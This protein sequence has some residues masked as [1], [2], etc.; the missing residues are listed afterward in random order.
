MST[1]VAV[2]VDGDNL[3]SQHAAAILAT[4]SAQGDVIAAKVYGNSQALANWSDCVDFQIIYSGTG[5]N[6]SDLHLAIELTELTYLQNLDVV[7]LCTSDADFVHLARRLKERG[8]KVLGC[9]EAKVGA[10]F[11]A[12]CTEFRELVGVEKKTVENVAD[13]TS[14]KPKPVAQQSSFTSDISKINW[15]I[16]AAIDATKSQNSG[17]QVKILGNY[18]KQNHEVTTDKLQ[19]KSWSK[20]LKKHEQLFIVVS[21]GQNAK[22]SYK[23]EGFKIAQVAS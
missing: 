10:G 6:A 7:V 5:K 17:M 21:E 14:T 1:K 9:G 8:I 15:Q 11:K 20:H 23:P 12:A 13:K 19:G 2:F 16:K 18:M 22:V 3:R 4:A